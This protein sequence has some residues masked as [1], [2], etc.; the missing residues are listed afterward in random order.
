MGINKYFRG[1]H[2]LRAEIVSQKIPVGS[3]NMHTYNFL[4]V[5]QSSQ[6]F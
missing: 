3:V 6:N 1:Q 5:D 4:S 2:A